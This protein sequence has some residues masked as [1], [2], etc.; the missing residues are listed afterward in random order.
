MLTIFWD[1]KT[2]PPNKKKGNFILKDIY[3]KVVKNF[4]ISPKNQ[5]KFKV[6]VVMT[7]SSKIR[8]LNNVYRSNNK[9]TDVLS[10]A[11]LD[12]NKK[13][14]QEKF[15][16]EKDTLGEIYI[17]YNWIEKGKNPA[18][19]LS[20]LFLHGYLHLLGYDHEKDRGEMEKLEGQIKKSIM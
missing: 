5:N 13:T 3:Q 19:S 12:I 8:G 10:F 11:E 17:N 15:L 16:I 1:I 4:N 6:K 14:P 2:T 7:S 20:E 18:K 9:E